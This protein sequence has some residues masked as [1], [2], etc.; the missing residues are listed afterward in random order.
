MESSGM[1]RPCHC[2][3]K[4]Q[5]RTA[6]AELDW[7][8]RVRRCFLKNKHF[9]SRFHFWSTQ[10]W[11]WKEK[12][13]FHFSKQSLPSH[14]SLKV[15]SC[16][17]LKLPDLLEQWRRWMLIM[18]PDPYLTHYFMLLHMMLFH[19]I[20]NHG[21]W[22]GNQQSELHLYDQSSSSGCWRWKFKEFPSSH[23]S[24]PLNK[25][26]SVNTKAHISFYE[27]V[28]HDELFGLLEAKENH[29]KSM[30]ISNQRDLKNP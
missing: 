8:T 3:C 30:K 22:S 2:P 9:S 7:R 21:F 1:P 5:N 20:P 29:G 13:S 26:D 15:F 6:P 25:F 11:L 24:Q 10:N 17:A 28:S 4:P 16:E 12:H 14:S 19:L 18:I 23:I 27:H